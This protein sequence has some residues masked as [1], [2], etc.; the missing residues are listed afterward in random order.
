MKNTEEQ[1]DRTYRK[2]RSAGNYWRGKIPDTNN[3]KQTKEID[4]THAKRRLTAIGTVIEGK[5]D[6]NKT[7]KPRQIMLDWMLV[8]SYRK[9]KEEPSNEL[10]DWRS[11]HTFEPALGGLAENQKEKSDDC[12]SYSSWNI[13]SLKLFCYRQLMLLVYYKSHY[14]K[15]TCTII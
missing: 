10:E 9:L 4:R 3:K 1:L 8:D 15:Y 12:K 14:F 11:T 2:R 13:S 7:K 5:M 6:G